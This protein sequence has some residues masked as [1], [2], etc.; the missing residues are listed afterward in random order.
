MAK[1]TT[2]TPSTPEAKKTRKPREAKVLTFDDHLVTLIK[3][4]RTLSEADR[5]QALTVIATMFPAAPEHRHTFVPPSQH[6]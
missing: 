1:E 4:F 6:D 5:R 3:T 2:T